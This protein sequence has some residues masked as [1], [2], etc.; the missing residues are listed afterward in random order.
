METTLDTSVLI[1][2]L[3]AVTGQQYIITNKA[4]KDPYCKGFRFGSGD[5]LVVARPGTLLELW[6][7]IQICAAADLQLAP[8]CEKQISQRSCAR[9]P[10]V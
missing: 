2:E 8:M 3:K 9:P 5:A 7:V 6:K 10:A 4:R 1:Q